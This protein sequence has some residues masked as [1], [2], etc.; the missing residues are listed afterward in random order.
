MN[1][2]GLRRAMFQGRSLETQEF[3]GVQQKCFG[4]GMAPVIQFPV[5]D[6]QQ[7][8]GPERD[9]YPSGSSKPSSVES[10]TKSVHAQPVRQWVIH[11]YGCRQTHTR[12]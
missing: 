11:L 7:R 10:S 6:G 12:L 5:L 4:C 3:E 9:R 8:V 1:V 2:F